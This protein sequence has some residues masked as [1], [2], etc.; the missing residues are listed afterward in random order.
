ME[1]SHLNQ[2][3]LKIICAGNCATQFFESATQKLSNLWDTFIIDQVQSKG[4]L[5]G[6]ISITKT[7]V[8]MVP[9]RIANR[10]IVLPILTKYA[11][12][13]WAIYIWLDMR[14]WSAKKNHYK[15]KKLNKEKRICFIRLLVDYMQ[16]LYLWIIESIVFI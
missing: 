15:L 11:I 13:K 12:Q 5:L 3:L 16:S 10:L 6:N 9:A 14:W 2:L 8:F 1:V 7:G 4:N